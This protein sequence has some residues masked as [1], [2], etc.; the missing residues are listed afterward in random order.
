MFYF[1]INDTLH[2]FPVPKRCGVQRDKEPLSDAIPNGVKECIFC[3]QVAMG[4]PITQT[5]ML[6]ESS[7][8]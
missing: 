3:M 1:V 4:R 8:P 7:I 6:T 2:R 5:L